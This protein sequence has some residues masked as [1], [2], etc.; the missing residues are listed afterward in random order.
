MI[1]KYSLSNFYS[2]V[3]SSL[4]F[5][6]PVEECSGVA[7][8]MTS[9]HTHLMS[10]P[11]LSMLRLNYYSI[12]IGPPDKLIAAYQDNLLSSPNND[13]MTVPL[14]DIASLSALSVSLCLREYI[15]QMSKAKSH[16][17]VMD[18]LRRIELCLWSWRTLCGEWVETHTLHPD[19]RKPFLRCA[20]MH[21]HVYTC[22]YIVVQIHCMY[23]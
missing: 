7:G 23:I 18:V 10:D 5:P 11:L 13:K 17:S 14:S 16:D 2:F 3:I 20:G 12:T 4:S 9:D 15:G 19:W 21:V 8:H 1:F 22:M 6:F